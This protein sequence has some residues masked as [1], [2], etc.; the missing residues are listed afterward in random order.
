M[1]C[2]HASY[3]Q[4][5]LASVPARPPTCRLQRFL[6]GGRLAT[7]SADGRMFV[8]D[9]ASLEALA[10]WKVPSCNPLGGFQA[11]CQF[12]STPDG[13]LI[14]VV[15]AGRGCPASRAVQCDAM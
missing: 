13:Q 3:P 2:M 15:S 10:G 6:P 8:W 11:R 5:I 12:S 4:P 7:K 1:A 9:L 14:C